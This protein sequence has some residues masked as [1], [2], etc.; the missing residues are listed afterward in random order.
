MLNKSVIILD[1]HAIQE[2]YSEGLLIVTVASPTDQLCQPVQSS[3]KCQLVN[4]DKQI[5]DLE[6]SIKVTVS[7][8]SVQ[9]DY[10]Y[11]TLVIFGCYMAIF[12]ISLVI[13]IVTFTYKMEHFEDLKELISATGNCVPLVTNRN[14]KMINRMKN[15]G[16]QENVDYDVDQPSSN[17]HNLLGWRTSFFINP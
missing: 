11:G 3:S 12:F 13:S 16:S 1:T 17:H 8:N 7:Y 10:L 9:T 2:K 5:Q 15:N 6:K 14:E 4:G